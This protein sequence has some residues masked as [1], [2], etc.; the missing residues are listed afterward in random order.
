MSFFPKQAGMGI[1]FILVLRLSIPAQFTDYK[2]R[3]STVNE[4]AKLNPLVG[5]NS[6]VGAGLFHL[7]L[8]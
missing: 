7:A 2:R 6:G 4:T 5:D 8:R 1:L 3:H